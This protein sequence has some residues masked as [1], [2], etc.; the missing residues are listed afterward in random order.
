LSTQLGGPAL[1]PAI[2]LLTVGG[3]LAMA[4]TFGIAARFNTGVA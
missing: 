1:R 2:V 4:V 3:A